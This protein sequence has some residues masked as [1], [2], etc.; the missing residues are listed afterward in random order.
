MSSATRRKTA[1][2]R[3]TVPTAASGRKAPASAEMQL[4]PQADGGAE[5]G[6][7]PGDHEDESEDGVDSD[8][9]AAA[10]GA[11]AAGSKPRRQGGQGRRKI[12]I[13]APVSLRC[14]ATDRR[15]NGRISRPDANEKA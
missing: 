9:M 10:T 6:E 1:G 11:A 3:A 12:P 7:E 4:D 8:G 15:G 14:A 5:R 13:G 2:R